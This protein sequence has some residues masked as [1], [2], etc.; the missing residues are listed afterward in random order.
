MSLT[1]FS[2]ENHSLKARTTWPKKRVKHRKLA[3]LSENQS[4]WRNRLVKKKKK[5]EEKRQHEQKK[6]KQEKMKKR[7]I[8]EKDSYVALSSCWTPE[9]MWRAR[10]N[11]SYGEKKEKKTT[12]DI[13]NWLRK[14]TCLKE[15][16]RNSLCGETYFK[17]PSS[18]LSRDNLF[19]SFHLSPLRKLDI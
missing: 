19:F 11:A 6:S 8:A 7:H 2:W 13:F 3:E 16:E 10:K 15:Q 1:A 18:L 5:R 4:V 9:S 14:S 17:L 12:R